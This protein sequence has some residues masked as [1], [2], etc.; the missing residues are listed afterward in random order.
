MC[1]GKEWESWT[2][3]LCLKIH[4]YIIFIYC[5]YCCTEYLFDIVKMLLLWDRNHYA[6]IK[7]LFL[8]PQILKNSFFWLTFKSFALGK[9]DMTENPADAYLWLPWKLKSQLLQTLQE[10]QMCLYQNNSGNTYY[11]ALFRLSFPPHLSSNSPMFS[12]LL[13]FG[14]SS[15]GSCAFLKALCHFQKLTG[16]TLFRD[17]EKF[18]VMSKI[19]LLDC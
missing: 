8:V 6:A 10:P 3:L 1:V 11:I 19:P 17:D 4:Y 16:I 14:N 15:F 5:I 12:T 18:C 13:T 7:K 2:N 9:Y